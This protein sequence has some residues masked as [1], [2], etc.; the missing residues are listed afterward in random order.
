MSD[1]GK[2]DTGHCSGVAIFFS[3]RPASCGESWKNL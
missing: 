1:T 2:S 3:A